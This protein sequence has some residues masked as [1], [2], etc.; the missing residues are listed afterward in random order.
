MRIGLGV[1]ASV[2]EWP[3]G[4]V[5]VMRKRRL[6]RARVT[7][8]LFPLPSR[9][10]AA[11]IRSR[12]GPLR[13]RCR[14]PRRS[15]ALFAYVYGEEDGDGWGDFGE[16]NGGGDGEETGESGGVV[17]DAGSEDAGGVWIFDGIAD[18][19]GGEDGVEMCG[20]EDAGLGGVDSV[21]FVG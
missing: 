7:T 19:S 6:P 5:T 21:G 12:Q 1:P 18:G 9:A 8:V 20:E 15:L 10:M 3:P 4:P 14:M 11:A 2:Q 17:A 16:A 13:K